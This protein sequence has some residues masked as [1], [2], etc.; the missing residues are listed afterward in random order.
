MKLSKIKP[1]G[2]VVTVIIILVLINFWWRSTPTTEEGTRISQTE[3]V[4]Y[5]YVASA[6]REPFHSPACKWAK[7]ISP[8]NLIGFKTRDEALKSGRRPCKVCKP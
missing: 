7:R 1:I 5:K 8:D 3:V 6:L 2:I 4:Q